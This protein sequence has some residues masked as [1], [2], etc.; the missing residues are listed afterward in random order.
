MEYDVAIAGGGPSSLYAARRLA[1]NGLAVVV[2]ERK[3]EIGQAVNCTGIVG[4]D[5]FSEFRLAADSVLMDIQDV[6]LVSP[7]GTVHHYRHPVPFARILD[8][9]HFD[10]NLAREARARGVEIRT[11]TEVTD[12]FLKEEGAELMVRAS[13]QEARPVT[14]RAMVIATG[15]HHDLNK[16][17][18][19]GYPKRF[20]HGA[21]FEAECQSEGPATIYLGRSFAPGGFAWAVPSG[22]GRVKYGL[23]TDKNPLACFRRFQARHLSF[24]NGNFQETNIQFKPIAQGLVSKSFGHRVLALGEAAGQVKTTTGGGISFGLRCANIA[25]D[26]LS[27]MLRKG[28]GPGNPLAEYERRWKESIQKEIRVGY[29]ARRVWGRLGDDRIEKIFQ[30]AQTDGILPL[31]REKGNFDWHSELILA[32]LR[33]ASSFGLLAGVHKGLPPETGLQ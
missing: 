16:K 20:M 22:P 28:I 7:E 33:R 4:L 27:C 29:Y 6:R 2:L 26:V 30:L 17:L 13:A 18:G 14:A 31:V 9:A 12:V 3:A 32:L 25:A 8:R 15:I 21:Q 11:G 19:L 10:R 23:V 24:L 1:E 5:I